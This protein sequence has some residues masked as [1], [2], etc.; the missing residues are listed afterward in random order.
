MEQKTLEQSLDNVE[1]HSVSLNEYAQTALAA[2]AETNKRLCDADAGVEVWLLEDDTSLLHVEHSEDTWT[3]TELGYARVGDK[4]C[5]AVRDTEY[6]QSGEALEN[7]AVVEMTEP[8]SLLDAGRLVRLR[9]APLLVR[10][11]GKIER[12]LEKLAE[13]LAT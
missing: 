6:K 8:K 12:E 2:V 7:L 5:L 9:A 11:V 1:R 3:D 4:F 13:G 10:V